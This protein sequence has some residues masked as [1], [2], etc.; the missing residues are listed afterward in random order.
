MDMNAFGPLPVSW[1]GVIE[2]PSRDVIIRWAPARE[3]VQ[4]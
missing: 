3:P 2:R 4:E 1:D